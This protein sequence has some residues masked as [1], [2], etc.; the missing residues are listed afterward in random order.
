MKKGFDWNRGVTGG[1]VIQPKVF[2]I[3]ELSRTKTGI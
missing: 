2:C 1:S 3:D